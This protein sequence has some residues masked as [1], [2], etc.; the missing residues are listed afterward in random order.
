MNAYWVNADP[1][2][3]VKHALGHK[4]LDACRACSGLE[5]DVAEALSC[6]ANECALAA[7][8]GTPVVQRERLDAM[9]AFIREGIERFDDDGIPEL[10]RLPVA[11]EAERAGMPTWQGDLVAAMD[12]AE[13]V[14][15][16]AIC[17]IEVTGRPGRPQA[18]RRDWLMFR[19]DEIIARYC[20][21]CGAEARA[22]RVH[23]ILLA[24]GVPSPAAAKEVRRIIAKVGKTAQKKA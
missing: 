13:T 9:L 15:I 6:Y 17:A 12:V 19:L 3:R 7:A 23:A 10:Y 21:S 22:G 18:L 24:A 5:R 4:D 8:Q 11:L 16:R 14:L 2:A 20:T 1:G